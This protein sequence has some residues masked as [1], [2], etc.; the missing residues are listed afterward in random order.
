MA[1][2]VCF[3]KQVIVV[4]EGRRYLLIAYISIFT[5]IQQLIEF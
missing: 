2:S 4:N 5:F 1:M 3:A